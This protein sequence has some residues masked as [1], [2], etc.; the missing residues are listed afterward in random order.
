MIGFSYEKIEG[1]NLVSTVY[2]ADQKSMRRIDKQYSIVV[3][4]DMASDFQLVRTALSNSN[5]RIIEA[6]NSEETLQCLSNQS[7]DVVLLDVA[8]SGMSDPG[9]GEKIRQ[10][11]AMPGISE[12]PL[13]MLISDED[14]DAI[15]GLNAGAIDFVI[16][17]F[18]S[19]E[20]RARLAVVVE[21]IRLSE[22]LT[23]ARRAAE[24]VRRSQAALLTLMNQ[25]I[26]TPMNAMIGL[27]YLGL[28]ARL[29][30]T[31]RTYLEKI[32]FS[33][34][35]LLSLINDAIDFSRIEGGGLKLSE[36]DFNVRECLTQVHDLIGDLARDKGLGFKLDISEEIPEMLCGD[37][38]R[39]GQMLINITRT[40]VK[41][42][43]KGTVTFQVRVNALN[44]DSVELLFIVRGSGIN[45]QHM[46][47]V[48]EGISHAYRSNP[49]MPG[50]NTLRLAISRELI[51]LMQ[52]RVWVERTSEWDS[53]FHCTAHFK[54]GHHRAN[55]EASLAKEPESV[56]ARINGARILVIEDNPTDQ[57]IIRDLLEL[58][59]AV[60]IVAGKEQ[61]A[62]DRLSIEKFDVVIINPRLVST[63]D[64]EA[65]RR[66]RAGSKNAHLRIIAL[67]EHAVLAEDRERYVLGDM[68]DY[69]PRPIDPEQMYRMLAK[70][71]PA[72]PGISVDEHLEG[73]QSTKS[74][75]VDISVLHQ[76]FHNNATL[77]RKFGLKFV[78][79]ANDTLAE[80]NLA[81]AEKDLPA[82]GR[83]GHKLKSSARTIGASSF[84][85]LCE[86]L[87]KANLN[88][89]WSNAE[90]LL[91]QIPV[92]LTQITQQ[93]EQEFRTMDK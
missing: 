60:A 85:D 1:G 8:L 71:L 40:V 16:K 46:E 51:D 59:G 84:A 92:L 33:A 14:V 17:P 49:L 48:S 15:N 41:L 32:N 26:Q 54:R 91:K 13:V 55:P 28:Q 75:P 27:S 93:L 25:E 44:D 11:R 57:L 68:D 61:D 81:Q 69:L 88:N 89:N 78:E 90:S 29:D 64:A 10:M 5:F 43:E 66:I 6:K 74:P 58:A 87:E 70:W 38:A 76:M 86:K 21:R 82:L 23:N 80:M 62:T 22:E 52:G 3:A 7:I 24:S 34:R 36:D 67:T 77:V 50:G 53:S 9:V 42:T 56:K 63:N 20:L 73:G 45:P 12:V 18:R 19:G 72:K 37:V 47:C 83:L 30:K 4:V 39:L 2:G 35:S 79:V 65:V 31:P